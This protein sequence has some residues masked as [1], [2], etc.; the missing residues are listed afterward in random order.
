LLQDGTE[1]V[2]REMDWKKCWLGSVRSVWFGVDSNT[3]FGSRTD[4]RW[5]QLVDGVVECRTKASIV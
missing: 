2:L 1:C 5:E 4:G 3:E